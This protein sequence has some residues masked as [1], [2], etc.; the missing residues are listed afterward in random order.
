MFVMLNLT[1]YGNCRYSW[2][3]Q[4]HGEDNHQVQMLFHKI[5]RYAALRCFLML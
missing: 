1:S 3:R 5:H 4:D 2:L